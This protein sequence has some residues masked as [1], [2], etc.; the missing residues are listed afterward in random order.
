MSAPCFGGKPIDQDNDS[1]GAWSD[2][3]ATTE[4]GPDTEE[5]R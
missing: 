5:T 1:L 2:G 3:G 4:P